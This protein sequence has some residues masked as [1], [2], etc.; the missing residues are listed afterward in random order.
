[1]I[2]HG[3][4]QGL[5]MLGVVDGLMQVLNTAEFRLQSY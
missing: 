3:E 1:L 2:V 5:I 4:R